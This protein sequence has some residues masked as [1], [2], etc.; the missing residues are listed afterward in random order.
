MIDFTW[1]SAF[2]PFW[3]NK[4]KSEG[5]IPAGKRNPAVVA[6]P[7]WAS[8]SQ[9]DNIMCDAM[10]CKSKCWLK[11]FNPENAKTDAGM[12]FRTWRRKVRS[13][14]KTPWFCCATSLGVKHSPWPVSMSKE[15]TGD[16]HWYDL[17]AQCPSDEKPKWLGS[18]FGSKMGI[19][20]NHATCPAVKLS[21][22]P[23]RYFAEN[24]QPFDLF[25]IFFWNVSIRQQLVFNCP[26]PER[27]I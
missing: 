15:I 14:H 16:I 9:A 24:H 21:P 20:R 22:K 19:L 7:P 2:W 6:I 23:D 13:F 4:A 25:W 27:V 26:C 17:N 1:S 18:M 3:P 10:S 12:F 5:T 11:F 8:W